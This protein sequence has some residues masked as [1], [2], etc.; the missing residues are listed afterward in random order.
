MHKLHRLG[1]IVTNLYATCQANM[2]HGA[3]AH[4]G[5]EVGAFIWTEGAHPKPL[6]SLLSEAGT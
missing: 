3:A 1:R 2:L 4:H 5:F 6:L